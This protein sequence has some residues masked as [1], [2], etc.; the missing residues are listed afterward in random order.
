M[1][2]P[3]FW[4]EKVKHVMECFTHGDE[5]KEFWKRFASLHKC[6]EQKCLERRTCGQVN[7]LSSHSFT[8]ENVLQGN[9]N[10]LFFSSWVK[11]QKNEG[12]D[13]LGKATGEGRLSH[14]T[15][16]YPFFSLI[17]TLPQ[18][19]QCENKLKHSSIPKSDWNK[20]KC[21]KCSWIVCADIKK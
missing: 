4:G 20:H 17:I 16:P 13:W 18:Q 7:I 8:P 12:S 5:N 15:G 14:T 6:E 3:Y 10:C 2:W 21:F 9:F 1:E 19:L 11:Y